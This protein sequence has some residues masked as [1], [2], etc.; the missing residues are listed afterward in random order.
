MTTYLQTEF[1]AFHEKIKLHDK[2]DNKELRDKRDML[3]EE[4]R[5]YFKKKSEDEGTS[6]ITFSIENQGS[7]SMGTGIRPL[8]DCDYDIDV[9]V[10][11]NISKDDYAPVE[12]KKWVYEALNR[13]NRTVEY[14][15]PC[16]RVQYYKNGQ[17]TFHVDLALYANQN[18]DEKKYL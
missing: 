10:L 14:K 16:V 5:A 7:Y 8:E 11:F 17:E 4:L 3:A 9:M 12:V 6:R 2:E 1:N 18:D 15:K 13:H